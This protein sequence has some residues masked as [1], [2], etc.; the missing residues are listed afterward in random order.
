MSWNTGLTYHKECFIVEAR[1]KTI[2]DLI[3]QLVEQKYEE[4]FDEL[5]ERNELFARDMEIAK[6]ATNKE[7]FVKLVPPS[8]II[9]PRVE[10]K[11]SI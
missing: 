4:Y 3:S 6:F 11:E 2:N 1:K 7:D 8:T 5:T 9:Q 10:K